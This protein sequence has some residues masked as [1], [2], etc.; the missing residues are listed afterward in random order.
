MAKREFDSYG[1]GEVRTAGGQLVRFTCDFKDRA[2]VTAFFAEHVRDIDIPRTGTVNI[3]H[4]GYGRYTRYDVTQHKYAGYGDGGG[5]GYIEVLE[6]KDPPN[7]RNGFVILDYRSHEGMA[8]TE[9]PSLAAALAGYEA[10][11]KTSREYSDWQTLGCQRFVSCG[12]LDPWFYAI[13]DQ[14]LIGDYAFPEGLQDDPVYRTGNKFVVCPSEDDLP[15]VKTCL[16]TR[17]FSGHTVDWAGRRQS[18]QR[19]MV[20]WDDGAVTMLES[21]SDVPNKGWIRPLEGGELWV[22]EALA[23]FRVLITGKTDQFSI[24]F[25]DGT[26]F[27]GRVIPAKSPVDLTRPG[28]YYAELKVTGEK[29]D[30]KGVFNFVPSPELPDAVSFVRAKFSE[31]GQQIEVLEIRPNKTKGKK[32]SGVFFGRLK[33]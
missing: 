16:G 19:R 4:G 12:L 7:E 20:H 8:F 21:G 14:E 30:R 22:T 28:S 32:W 13:G 26:Q 9:W 27:V 1:G 2:K 24:K 11:W 5:G 23:Q 25:L 3:P 33:S 29:K 10:F 17:F 15:S 6:I 31:K 18:W